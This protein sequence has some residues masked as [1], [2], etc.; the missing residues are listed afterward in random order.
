MDCLTPQSGTATDYENQ[1]FYS[2]F[3]Q[4]LN[5]TLNA[6]RQR[7]QQ[8]SQVPLMFWT[9]HDCYLLM[10][11]ARTSPD[12]IDTLPKLKVASDPAATECKSVSCIGF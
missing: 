10:E 11:L 4:E 5:E 8:G 1:D 7:R 6:P 2:V 3:I 9:D 12:M